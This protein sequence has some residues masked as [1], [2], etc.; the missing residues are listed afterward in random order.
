MEEIAGIKFY[1]L[2]EIPEADTSYMLPWRLE[3]LYEI[4]PTLK[5]IAARAA[6]NKRRRFHARIKTYEQAK[7]AAWKFVGWGARDP[8]LRSSGAWDCFFNRVLRDLR[9]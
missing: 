4:E 3:M 2:A 9:L 8:R 5:E 6:A 1:T 7:R